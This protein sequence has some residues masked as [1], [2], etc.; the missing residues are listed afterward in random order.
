M[1]VGEDII[2]PPAMKWDFRLGNPLTNR[3]RAGG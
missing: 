3:L 2:L 1:F